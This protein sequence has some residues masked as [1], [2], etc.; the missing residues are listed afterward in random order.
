MGDVLWVAAADG[1]G[2]VQ[3]TVVAVEAVQAEGMFNPYTNEGARPAPFLKLLFVLRR[4][5]AL[6]CAH[7]ATSALI[8][9]HSTCMTVTTLPQPEFA[10]AVVD[11]HAANWT[12]DAPCYWAPLPYNVYSTTAAS[13]AQAVCQLSFDLICR[14]MLTCGSG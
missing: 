9:R 3:D 7:A 1:H 11:P 2:L 5:P 14:H 12:L 6:S 8:C 10:M 4:P 13:K